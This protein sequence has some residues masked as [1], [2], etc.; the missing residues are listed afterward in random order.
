MLGEEEGGSGVPNFDPVE[1]V[2]LSIPASGPA[3]QVTDLLSESRNPTNTKS[4]E[5]NSSARDSFTHQTETEYT[6]PR[7][8][9]YDTLGENTD[10]LIPSIQRQVPMPDPTT[11][12][13]NGWDMAIALACNKTD[14]ELTEGIY[15]WFQQNTE[16]CQ[17]LLNLD[18]GKCCLILF[19]P[20]SCY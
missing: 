15:R 2:N 19:S 20:N 9:T 7:R 13:T 8:L 1:E 4:P 5:R 18:C 17:Y 10:K 12:D 11:S 14:Y 16:V 3:T 6:S